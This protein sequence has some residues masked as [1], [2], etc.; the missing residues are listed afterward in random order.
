MRE[1]KQPKFYRQRLIL[2]L[3]T[4]ADGSLSKMDF[5]K[6]LFLLHQNTGVLYYDFVPYHFGCY[7]FQA[8]SDLE[9]L[10]SLGWIK[11]GEKKIT[12]LEKPP[13][14]GIQRKDEIDAIRSFMKSYI[15]YRGRK[16]LHFI[17]QNY[18]YY[19]IKSKIAE[20]LVD[21]KVYKQI[22]SEKKRTEK[23]RTILYTLGYEGLTFEKYVN[24]LVKNDVLLICDV[25]KNPLS[26]K[27]G[28]SKGMMSRVLPKL[29]IEY[30]HIPELGIIS[31]KRKSLKAASDY[32]RLFN[33]YRKTLPEKSS[34]LQRLEELLNKKKRIALTCF[35]KDPSYCHRHCLSAYLEAK[36][37]VEV[38]H[39]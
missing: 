31:N 36:K 33:D 15:T 30:L 39:L 12:L 26:R 9:T 22:I 7:S 28:F 4:E 34:Y 27:F 1:L 8:A 38:V 10:Q 16:L 13:L 25:R 32:V 37:D 18:P 29:G 20:D 19:A 23:K 11:L 6:L 14:R 17:Y 35:E 3:L 5:Q 2:T 24:Q 21:K